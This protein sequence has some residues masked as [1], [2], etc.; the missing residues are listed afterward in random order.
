MTEVHKISVR[1]SRGHLESKELAATKADLPVC[2][3]KVKLG[4]TKNYKQW[5]KSTNVL[6]L[7]ERETK[8]PFQQILACL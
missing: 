2:G 6:L 8:A 7:L 4:Y 1:R 5:P 3:T